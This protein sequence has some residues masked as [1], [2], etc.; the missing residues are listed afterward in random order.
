MLQCASDQALRRM[1]RQRPS[2]AVGTHTRRGSCKTM[3]AIEK[4]RDTLDDR[5]TAP[6]CT[7]QATCQKTTRPQGLL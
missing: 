6:S 7:L 3:A 4:I 2:Q 5:T 1:L